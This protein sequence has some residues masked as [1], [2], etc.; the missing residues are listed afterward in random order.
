MK[1]VQANAALALTATLLLPTAVMAKT[2]LTKGW[3]SEVLSKEGIVI[4]RYYDP[5]AEWN[6]VDGAL[7][8]PSETP[9]TDLA[10]RRTS[11]LV[12]SEAG[13]YSFKVAIMPPVLGDFAEQFGWKGTYLTGVK[14]MDFSDCTVQ[15]KLGEK[16][17]ADQTMEVNN[18][19][20]S[21]RGDPV[22][23][24]DAG[25]Q[26][27]FL[28]AMG[29]A[30]VS[31][32]DT[33]SVIETTTET[34]AKGIYDLNVLADCKNQFQ[35]TAASRQVVAQMQSAQKDAVGFRFAFST[36]NGDGKTEFAVKTEDLTNV[37]GAPGSKAL[38]IGAAPVI[39]DGYE[40]GWLLSVFPQQ[41]TTPQ[42][43]GW[44][45]P[46]LEP[47]FE[48][49]AP[50]APNFMTT[51]PAFMELSTV[52]EAH[53]A[54]VAIGGSAMFTAS[55]SGEHV[56]SF[57]LTQRQSPLIDEGGGLGLQV[58]IHTLP[59]L[60][61]VEDQQPLKGVIAHIRANRGA[62]VPRGN[63]FVD[64]VYKY[65]EV[66][67]PASFTV[68]LE[69]GKTY[70]VAFLTTTGDDF[71][72]APDRHAITIDERDPS[73]NC[74]EYYKYW[75]STNSNVVEK[76]AGSIEFRVK[77]PSDPGLRLPKDHEILHK[78][79]EAQQG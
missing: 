79:A 36:T 64:F 43:Q 54:S 14:E 55:E 34:L 1:Y 30:N 21:S 6:P 46:Q 78:A 73:N 71:C 58:F 63:G 65:G 52:Y 41:Q 45:K 25:N 69:K 77:T 37:H 5:D 53:K 51:D 22:E 27:S 44:G 29:K 70:R 23:K 75:S 66:S 47:T 61:K 76:T 50:T 32:L 15:V 72:E 39:P 24:L 38:R 26:N 62:E 35:E 16:V 11:K 7:T 13:E 28:A 67:E 56:F 12:V 40:P 17:I 74:L 57:D 2:E 20:L 42:F 33:N 60:F 3:I 59:L 4:S 10:I 49:V 8:L 19:D 68:D 48:W 18:A 31:R 9:A